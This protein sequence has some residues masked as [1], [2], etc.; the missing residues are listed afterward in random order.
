MTA[1]AV[2][3]AG[4]AL[5]IAAIASGFVIFIGELAGLWA[6]IIVNR[7]QRPSALA[8]KRR[9]AFQRLRGIPR[10]TCPTTILRSAKLYMLIAL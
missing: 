4:L 3:Y 10:P 7:P 6:L 5:V 2:A 9:L 1:Q 8:N